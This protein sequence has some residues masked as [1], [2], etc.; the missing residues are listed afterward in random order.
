MKSLTLKSH[1]H[2]THPPVQA[3]DMKQH[4]SQVSLFNT[5][6]SS[7]AAMCVR[8]PSGSGHGDHPEGGKGSK[9]LANSESQSQKLVKLPRLVSVAESEVKR[10]ASAEDILARLM[11]DAPPEMKLDDELRSLVLQV[12]GVD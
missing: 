2:H 7:A 1:F 3:T 12:W 9:G 11:G 8:L 4:F 6:M 10:S 5:K